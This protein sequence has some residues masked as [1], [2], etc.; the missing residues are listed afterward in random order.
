MMPSTSDS[1]DRAAREQLLLNSLSRL[2]RWARG[3]VPPSARDQM[4]TCDL[5]QE[6]ALH[7]FR[8]L[9]SF[10]PEHDGSMPAYL[11][12][13]ASNIVI[14]AVR[15]ARRRQ[16]APLNDAMPLPSKDDDPLTE[17]MRSEARAHDRTALGALRAKDRRLLIA[18][19]HLEWGYDA[20]ARQLALPS[21]DAARMALRRAERRLHDQLA[22]VAV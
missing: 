7:T 10:T 18:R 16:P 1:I 11:Q 12:R 13:A 9:G 4:D 2:K 8:C 17:T 19:H 20:I 22:G 5:V 15:R 6:A 21:A 3:R 14:D